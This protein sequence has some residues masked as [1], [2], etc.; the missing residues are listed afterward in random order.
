[1]FSAEVSVGDS[2]IGLSPIPPDLHSETYSRYCDSIWVSL[3][4]HVLSRPKNE[5]WHFRE[6][7]LDRTME[8][9]EASIPPDLHLLIY[10]SISIIVSSEIVQTFI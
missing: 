6:L 5:R 1:M 7:Q 9:S 4:G 10:T 8:H 2:I 3:R